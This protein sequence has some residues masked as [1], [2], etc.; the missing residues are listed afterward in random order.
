MNHSL[1]SLYSFRCFK[2]RWEKQNI[3]LCIIG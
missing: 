3:S 2:G 1:T